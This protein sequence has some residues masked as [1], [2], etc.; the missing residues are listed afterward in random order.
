MNP[1]ELQEFKLELAGTA[2]A[3]GREITPAA[4]RIYAGDL[5]AY[6]LDAA[7]AALRDCRRSLSRF[8]TVSDLIA[9]IESADGRPGAEEAWAMVPK[10]EFGSCVWTIEMATAYGVAHSHIRSGDLIA[11][12]LAFK[13]VYEREVKSARLV[14]MPATWSASLGEDTAGHQAALSEAV[15]K[16]RITLEYAAKLTPLIESRDSPK[17]LPAPTEP[18]TPPE[19][20]KARIQGLIA[21]IG[22]P[23]P[24]GES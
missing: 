7:L 11:A 21:Q 6:P 23:V 1:T 20:V 22:K 16:N 13:E 3:M 2:E 12:R 5:E 17:A 24:G 4:V 15:Q 18:T 10:D 14:G 19:Q 8:P 9:K